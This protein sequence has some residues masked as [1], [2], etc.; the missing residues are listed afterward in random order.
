MM[1]ALLSSW[2]KDRIAVPR[3]IRKSSTRI[4]R[5]PVAGLLRMG[6]LDRLKLVASGE[7]KRVFAT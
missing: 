3:E 4:V 1:A 7:L 5:G 2:I 6:V